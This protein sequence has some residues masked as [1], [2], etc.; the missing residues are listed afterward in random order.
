[1]NLDNI[2]HEK[3]YSE[4]EVY[5]CTRVMAAEI[6]QLFGDKFTEESPALVLSVLTGGIYFTGKVM[7]MFNFPMELSYIGFS[8]YGMAEKGINNIDDIPVHPVPTIEIEGRY[9]ILVDDIYDEGITINRL[10][11]FCYD[12]GA[13]HVLVVVM[14]HKIKE[15]RTLLPGPDFSAVR[16]LD[17]FLFGCG[18]DVAGMYRNAPGIYSK[19][20]EDE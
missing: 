12:A 3:V 19:G 15:K 10:K 9:V 5:H 20:H 4:E 8:R 11:N 18:L 14:V 1:M 17:K 13:K 2:D 16:T 7:T 6:N